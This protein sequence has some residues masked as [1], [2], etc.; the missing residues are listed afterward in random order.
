MNIARTVF[1]V[2]AA[3]LTVSWTHAAEPRSWL[4]AS[5]W[6]GAAVVLP[7]LFVDPSSS[8]A[9]AAG[10]QGGWQPE[11]SMPGNDLGGLEPAVLAQSPSLVTARDWSPMVRGQQV[12]PEQLIP[13]GQFTRLSQQ[14][15]VSGIGGWASW[16]LYDNSNGIDGRDGNFPLGFNNLAEEFQLNQAWLYATRVA[17]TGNGFDWGYR[18]DVLWGSDGPDTTAFGDQSWD[19]NWK[20]SDQ[21]GFAMPQL[22]LEL[23]FNRLDIIIGYFYTIIGYEVVQAPDNFFYSHSLAFYYHEPFTHTGFLANYAVTDALKVYGGW[24]AGWNT[25]FSNGNNGSTFLGGVKWTPMDEFYFFYATSFG[26]PGDD[27]A[28]TSSTYLQSLVF[29]F[30][31]IDDL[32]YVLWSDLQTRSSDVLGGKSYSISQYLYWTVNNR[33]VL[34][35][36][37]GWFREGRGVN[38]LAGASEHFHNVTIGLNRYTRSGIVLRPE[39]RG[40]WADRDDAFAGGAF[41]NGTKQS[42]LTWGINGFC[43]F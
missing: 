26:D 31:F 4:P 43:T 22:F 19:F 23:A 14:D 28:S 3:A 24:T 38:G 25:G 15:E 16:G 12:V 2:L 7:G 21:Y 34:G 10:E 18:I 1:A 30:K 36:R 41:A 33:T 29:D 17:E 9:T 5:S 37:Y 42:Q 6:D 11:A 20:T 8:T 40:D 35:L 13:R 27:P 39:I 32:E